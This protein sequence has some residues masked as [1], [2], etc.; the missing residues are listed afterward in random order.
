M[1][2]PRT[3]KE[4]AR[5]LNLPA[6]TRTLAAAGIVGP[7]MFTVG[8]LVQQFYR[9]GDY[10]PVAQLVS[11]L[12][13]GRYGWVQQV[14]FIVFGLLMV[15]FAVG[16]HQGVHPSRARAVSPAILGF[17]AAGLVLAGIFPL[18]ADATGRVYDP[19]GVHTVNGAIFFAS[20]GIV[21]AVVSLRLRAD[22]RW[23][24]LATYTLVTGIALLV[25]FAVV[26]ALARPAGT[27]LHD[28]LGLL[29]RLVL[30]VWLACI[31][32][33]ALRLRRVATQTAR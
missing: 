26:V 1:K 18:R 30:T 2:A 17:N 9:R 23:R 8:I 31:V 20:I 16:L 15:A 19:I 29:Q 32:V 28:R 24:G 12:T 25:L 13:A 14:N 6:T 4:A 11:D 22:P 5:V 3:D 21:L 10:D 27:P 33:V 7:V